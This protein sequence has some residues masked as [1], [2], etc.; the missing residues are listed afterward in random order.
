MEKGGKVKTKQKE[1]GSE[2]RKEYVV[3][4]MRNLGNIY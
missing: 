3:R 1:G 2:G 4:N